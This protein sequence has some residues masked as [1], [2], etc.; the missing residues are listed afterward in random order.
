MRIPP[1][2]SRRSSVAGG[3]QCRRGS[4][5]C[6]HQPLPERRLCSTTASPRSLGSGRA[7]WSPR[8]SAA[9]RYPL[10]T[11]TLA[12]RSLPRRAFALRTVEHRTYQ[13]SAGPVTDRWTQHRGQRHLRRR[14]LPDRTSGGPSSRSTSTSPASQPADEGNTVSRHGFDIRPVVLSAGAL[15]AVTACGSGAGTTSPSA[16]TGPVSTP[17]PATSSAP[18]TTSPPAPTHTSGPTSATAAPVRQCT[19][20]TLN[21]KLGQGDMAAGNYYI[22]VLFTNTGAPCRITGYPGVSYYA[23]GDHHQVGDAAARDSG[24]T[25]VVVLQRGQTA[26]AMVNQVNVSHYDAEPCGPTPVTGLRVY[27]PGNTVPVLLPEPD[28]HACAKHMPD[29]RPLSVRAVQRGT[30]AN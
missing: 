4:K 17:P 12:A 14:T 29:Q 6:S 26:S 3:E 11:R 21:I 30:G 13:L 23:G 10:L 24:A 18:T 7:R 22:P 15:L 1:T 28:A 25:P 5:I 8:S 16:T 2:G 9:S 27:P 19:T 20:A